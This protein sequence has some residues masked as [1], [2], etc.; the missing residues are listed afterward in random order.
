M[1]SHKKLIEQKTNRLAKEE[2]KD[3]KYKWV[4]KLE[5]KKNSINLQ[6]S[7]GGSLSYRK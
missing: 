1:K 2:M 4:A 3:T 6:R 5:S 7:K